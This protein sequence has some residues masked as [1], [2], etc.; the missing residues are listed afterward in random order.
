MSLRNFSE[1]KPFLSI[2]IIISTLFLIVFMQMEERRIGYSVLKLSREYK[3]TL[4]EKRSRE[5]TLAK[6]TRP[7]LLDSVAQ[8]KFALKKAQASQII[9]LSGPVEVT[10]AVAVKKDM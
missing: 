6:V 9:H 3:K 1:L 4:D 8:T 10:K 7:Q 2:V 5:V